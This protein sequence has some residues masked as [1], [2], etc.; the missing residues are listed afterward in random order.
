M[1]RDKQQ[2]L[3]YGIILMDLLSKDPKLTS[4]RKIDERLLSAKVKKAI[5]SI[6]NNKKDAASEE[7]LTLADTMRLRQLLGPLFND[8]DSEVYGTLSDTLRKYSE[9]LLHYETY[10]KKQKKYIISDL[11]RD[12]SALTEYIDKIRKEAQ[13]RDTYYDTIAEHFF[14]G[15]QEGYKHWRMF[16]YKQIVMHPEWFAMGDE[17]TGSIVVQSW[18]PYLKKPRE[19]VLERYITIR[20]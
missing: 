18:D 2:A 6:K 8:P 1:V 17:H 4:L 20:K 13:S 12:L 5:D 11:K 7:L 10:D 19:Q 3:E 9:V 15:V 14:A 16:N